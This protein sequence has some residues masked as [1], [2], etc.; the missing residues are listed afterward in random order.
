MG[1]VNLELFG[2]LH[3]VVNAPGA[4]FEAVLEQHAVLITT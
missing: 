4:L 2:H 3:N 1:A